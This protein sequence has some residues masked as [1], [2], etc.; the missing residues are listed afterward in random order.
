[1]SLPFLGGLFVVDLPPSCGVWPAEGGSIWS[2]AASASP[3]GLSVSA[4]YTVSGFPPTARDQQIN[5]QK[6]QTAQNKSGQKSSNCRFAQTSSLNLL[7]QKAINL[8]N[9][10]YFI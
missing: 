4:G 8:E 9:K 10:H 3:V 6:C 5:L 1:M 7:L 2:D